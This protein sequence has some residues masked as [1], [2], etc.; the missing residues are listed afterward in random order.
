MKKRVAILISGR[1]SNMMAL[2]EAAGAP[3]YPAEMVLVISN[4]P[5][6]P[7]LQRARLSGTGRLAGLGS[8]SGR[9]LATVSATL[10]LPVTGPAPP[11]AS[12]APARAAGRGPAGSPPA[13]GPAPPARIPAP[14][15]VAV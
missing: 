9:R 6:A 14:R 4:R 8:S 7:G 3:D 12:R 2:V 5:D 11:P 15:A 10:D 13:R 1:G